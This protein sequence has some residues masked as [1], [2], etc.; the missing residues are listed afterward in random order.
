MRPQCFQVVTKNTAHLNTSTLSW[1][2]Q[3]FEA[4]FHL[5]TC[6]RRW[7]CTT[8]GGILGKAL[9]ME[10]QEA[11]EAGD[12]MRVASLE[13]DSL[14]L[15]SRPLGRTRSGLSLWWLSKHPKL[16]PPRGRGQL[17]SKEVAFLL[18]TQ[19][20]WVWFSVFP[21]I[22]FDVVEIY[23]W[24]WLEES[25]QMLENVDQTHLVLASDKL[26]LQ[27]RPLRFLKLHLFTTRGHRLKV[28][29]FYV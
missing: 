4:F 12:W 19:Q 8:A 2:T 26:V 9:W 23:R 18:L 24:R 3:R 20:P 7:S 22:Y 11:W 10:R 29:E 15:K 17:H 6:K 16:Y 25:G 28:N 5:A 27:K 14:G 1:K 21:K 13:T